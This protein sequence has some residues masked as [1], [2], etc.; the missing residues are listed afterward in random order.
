M[1]ELKNPPPPPPIPGCPIAE[2][3]LA[4]LLERIAGRWG[5]EQPLVP[6]VAGLRFSDCRSQALRDYEQGYV[7]EGVGAGG[8]A[9][10]WERC[11]HSPQELASA[12]DALCWQWLGA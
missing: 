12:C 3:P 9:L 4:L 11:G 1:S 7:K 2:P 10:L 8:L 5:L 6:Q